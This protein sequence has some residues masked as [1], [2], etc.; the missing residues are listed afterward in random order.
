[1]ALNDFQV[2]GAHIRTN[3]PKKPRGWELEFEE[4][5]LEHFSDLRRDIS[6]RELVKRYGCHATQQIHTA[7]APHVKSFHW[8]GIKCRYGD[9]LFTLENPTA[10][11][12]GE[13]YHLLY[14]PGVIHRSGEDQCRRL[15]FRDKISRLCD[16]GLGRGRCAV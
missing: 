10:E 12:K 14:V 16:A 13:R 6:D 11:H 5:T 1:M 7:W 8:V 15:E 2:G 9:L 3:L 4:A